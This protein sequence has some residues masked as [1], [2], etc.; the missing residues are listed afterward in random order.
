MNKE[1]ASKLKSL[2]LRFKT[3]K[4]ELA[5]LNMEIGKVALPMIIACDNDCVKELEIINLLPQD[6]LAMR[7]IYEHQIKFEET[8]QPQ[9]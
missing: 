9:S 6:C 5:D 7:R 3:L 8:T 2:T 1:Q 4:K